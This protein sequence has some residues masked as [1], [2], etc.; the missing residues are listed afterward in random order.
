MKEQ[1][2]KVILEYLEKLFPNAMCEL[3]FGNE[4]ELVVSVILSAQCTDKRVNAT[5]PALFEKYP[6]FFDLARASQSDVEEIIKPCGFFHNKAKNIIACSKVV[7]EKFG[8]KLPN[9]VEDM[10][11][12]PGV[13]MKTAKV[14]CANLFGSNVV[15][16]DTHV[17]RVSNRLGIVDESNPDKISTML[18]SEF[19]S[20]LSSVHHRFVLFGRYFCKSQRPNCNEC[21]LKSICK[22]YKM[23]N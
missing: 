10:M 6:T 11:T 7:V 17:K 16:V 18:E 22:Y 3:N 4:Y 20:N 14:V 12:L 21:E 15:A 19:E 2:K 5:T 9:S 13:G 8:D 1:E 23:Q